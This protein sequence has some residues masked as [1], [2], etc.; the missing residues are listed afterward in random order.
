VAQDLFLVVDDSFAQA[1]L[2]MRRLREAVPDARVER[3]SSD[4]ESQTLDDVGKLPK[5]G[6]PDDYPV[7]PS[8]KWAR[9]ERAL[10]HKLKQRHEGQLFMVV[11]MYLNRSDLHVLREE[12]RGMLPPMAP[13]GA[14]SVIRAALKAMDKAQVQ[15]RIAVLSSYL[16][17]RVFD[18][19]DRLECFKEHET[20]RGR[21]LCWLPIAVV[22]QEELYAPSTI[23]QLLY[24]SPTW[25]FEEARPR[26]P[27]PVPA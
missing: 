20:S 15:G 25:I 8:P 2:I 4:G 16:G 3:L 27:I 1:S 10:T 26:D 21:R 6:E 7:N 22:I 19:R 18:A 17:F 14:T 23:R 13:R 5:T 24:D 9:F 11:D 12:T